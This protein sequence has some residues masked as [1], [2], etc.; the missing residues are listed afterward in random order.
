MEEILGVCKR[1]AEKLY[2]RWLHLLLPPFPSPKLSRVTWQ[3]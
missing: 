2:Y 3:N 1:R